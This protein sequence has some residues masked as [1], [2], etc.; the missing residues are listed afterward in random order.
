L[1]GTVRFVTVELVLSLS[2]QHDGRIHDAGS[3]R[4]VDAGAIHADPV[5]LGQP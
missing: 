1:A 2:T 4:S 5:L 3:A